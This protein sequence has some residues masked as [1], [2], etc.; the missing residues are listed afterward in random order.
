MLKNIFVK[1]F[2]LKYSVKM[3]NLHSK[4]AITTTAFLIVA[5][6]VLFMIFEWI[7]EGTI[8][9][10]SPA[11]KALASLF[12]SVTLRTAGFASIPQGKLTPASKFLGVL[13][14]FI[15]GS[16]AGTAGG[17]KTVTIAVIIYTVI[18]VIN[19]RQNIIAHKRRISFEVLQK[20]LTIVT[21]MFICFCVATTMLTRTEFA[22]L[23]KGTFGFLDLLYEVTSALGTVGLTA[24]VTPFL[25]VA[26]KL[27]IC[28]CMFIGR[29]G[30]ITIAVSLTSKKNSDGIIT[31]PEDNVMVG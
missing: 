8:G 10:F 9:S 26:G 14:M 21:G 5:G 17:V 3:L 6:F 27:I 12:Q 16:P 19:G 23:E 15:G 13:F 22:M 29:L 31:Y 20:A 11:H 1:K 25:T 30:P 28:L 2:S 18:S 4:I 24:D 7:N